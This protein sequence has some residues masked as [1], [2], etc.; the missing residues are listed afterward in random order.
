MLAIRRM[1]FIFTLLVI[2]ILLGTLG[3]KTA[4]IIISLPFLLWY[5]VWDEKSYYSSKIEAEREY[6]E[7]LHYQEE[8]TYTYH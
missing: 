3:I 7:Y 5:M 4:L 1:G 6:E 2:G 8:Q